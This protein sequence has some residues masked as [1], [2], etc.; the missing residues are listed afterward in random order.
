MLTGTPRMLRLLAWVARLTWSQAR[1]Q[2]IAAAALIAVQG[3]M[4]VALLYLMKRIVDAVVQAAAS[5]EFSPALART[6]FVC[7]GLSFLAGLAIATG[8]TAS[9][10]IQDELSHRTGRHIHDT[11]CA[12][13]SRLDLARFEDPACRDLLHRTRAEAPHRPGRMIGGCMQ[14]AQAA[15]TLAGLAS[16]LFTFNAWLVPAAMVVAGPLLFTWWKTGSRHSY[17]QDRRLAPLERE[18]HYLH[19]VL[20]GD[21]FAGELRTFHTADRVQTRHREHADRLHDEKVRLERRRGRD[22]VLIQAA[23]SAIAYGGFAWLAWQALHG[24]LTAGDL[25]MYGAA[26][27]R[28]QSVFQ[29]LLRSLVALYEDSLFLAGYREFLALEPRVREPAAPRAWPSRLREGMVFDRVTFRYPRHETAA[30]RDV[31][32]EIRPG[33][34]TA[35]VGRNGSGKTTCLKLMLRLYDPGEG[36]VRL[37]GIDLSE[38]RSDEIHRHVRALYQDFPRYQFTAAENIRMG[39]GRAPPDGERIAAS[40]RLSGAEGVIAAL[41]STYD[42][43]LGAWFRGGMELSRG[44]WQ[45][46][47]LARALVSPAQILVLDE[48]TSAMDPESEALFLDRLLRARSDCAIVLISHRLSATHLADRVYVFDRGRVVEEGTPAELMRR[49]GLYAAFHRPRNPSAPE[50]GGPPEP[51]P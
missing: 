33:R 34:C 40:A 13:A 17:D 19:H 23:A 44:E 18:T 26:F 39:D 42:T 41:P 43:R 7:I 45:K 29:D 32:L 35:L 9:I 12:H 50:A 15:L 27:Q 20:I 47:A 6:A 24:R 30:L 28:A 49:D 1:G 11:L 2:A 10:L 37:E 46:I 36:R 14:S 3:V 51:S 5:G 21:D 25:V 8:R 48:P 22:H 38:F 16:I 4:P 31:T